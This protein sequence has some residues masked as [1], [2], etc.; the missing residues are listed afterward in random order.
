MPSKIPVSHIE[1]RHHHPPQRIG[2]APRRLV[3]RREANFQ[4]DTIAIFL[5][6]KRL[7]QNCIS[8]NPALGILLHTGCQLIL[9]T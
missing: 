4:L 1:R 7:V 8:A 3:L 5:S 9:Q 6:I 2:G